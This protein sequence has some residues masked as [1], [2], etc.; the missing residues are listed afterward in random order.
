M[1]YGVSTFGDIQSMTACGPEQPAAGDPQMSRAG[2]CL[3]YRLF[4]CVE[5]PPMS[6]VYLL[7]I[8]TEVRQ[9]NVLMESH[10]R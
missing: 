6:L 10:P 1:G 2:G 7:I 8:P 9:K 5:V 3:P 4:F